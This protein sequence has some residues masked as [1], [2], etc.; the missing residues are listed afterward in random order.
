MREVVGIQRSIQG[1]ENV[2]RCSRKDSGRSTS[3]LDPTPEQVAHRL[4]VLIQNVRELWL[5]LAL[6]LHMFQDGG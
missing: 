4:L 3:W 5:C 6:R 2:W 1:V